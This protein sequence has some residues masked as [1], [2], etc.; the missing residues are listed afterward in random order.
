MSIVGT[1][2][3]PLQVAIVGSG[4]AGFYAAAALLKAG[5][6]TRRLVRINMLERLP[7]PFG[8]VRY[9]VAPDHA[10]IKQASE[11][12]IETARD[13]A[14][15]YMGNVE[16]G[17]S[18][19]VVELVDSHHGVIFCTGAATDRRLGIPGEDLAGSH[20]ATEFVGWYNAHPDFRDCGFDLSPAGGGRLRPGQRGCRRVPDPG[21]HR[22]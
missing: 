18:L 4:P 16:L 12:Y 15:N 10:K 3:N 20:T 14:F 2:Q 17:R 13:P 11:K 9:G 7:A 21:Q 5:R 19:S 6:K 8:L 22:R 1:V